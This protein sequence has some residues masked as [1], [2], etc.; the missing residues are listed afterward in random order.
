[1]PKNL[2]ESLDVATLTSMNEEKEEMLR[3]NK[4]YFITRRTPK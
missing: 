4:K 2:Q 3:P 1:M